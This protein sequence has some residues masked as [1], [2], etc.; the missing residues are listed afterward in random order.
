MRGCGN[1]IPWQRMA[2]HDPSYKLLFSHRE[3][4]A[5][6]LRGFV[7][8]AWTRGLDFNTLER[9]R[10]IGVS[11]DL[12]ER[13][14][15]ILWRLRLNLDGRRRWL[16]LYLLLEFQSSVDAFMA[17]RLLTYIGL[18]YQDLL[19]AGEVGPSDALP[20]VL[21]VV[22]Y[23]GSGAWSARTSLG[24]LIEPALPTDL[25]AWQPQLRYL[26]L[27]QR[28]YGD[29]ELARQ[30]NL[31]AA[32]FR[33]ENSRTP[34]DIEQ[35][36]D[37]LVRW[38]SAAEQGDLRRAFVV[39]LKRVLLPARA[40]G[41]DLPNIIELQEMRDMLAERVKTWTEE[42]KAQGLTEGL[43][44]GLEQGRE[45]GFAEG[46]QEGRLDGEARVL[47]RQLARRFGVLPHWVDERLG[48]ASED[49]LETWADRVLDATGLDGVF[50]E[51]G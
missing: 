25:Q 27:V 2:E 8:E 51:R 16:Y 48:T 28:A 49:E 12:R 22:L 19:K 34:A 17:V 23:N 40:P 1:A 43:R 5:D 50:G 21:P 32:L 18:L 44:M 31:V 14:N 24:D 45:Q 3:M 7:S 13:E 29:A 9:V 6:L 10:E 33:L 41:A 37:Q 26:V 38:L 36:L 46:R 20:A 39:W 47:R 42:W 4:V 15:D 30:R 11:H 35:V